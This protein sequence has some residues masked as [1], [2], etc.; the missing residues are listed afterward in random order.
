MRSGALFGV[1]ASAAAAATT[2]LAE[3]AF[4]FR[5]G[6]AGFGF[7]GAFAFAAASEDPGALSLILGNIVCV[8]DPWG[9]APSA[10]VP[11]ADFGGFF[12]DFRLAVPGG[13]GCWPEAGVLGVAFFFDVLG[14]FGFVVAAFGAIS[15]LGANDGGRGACGELLKAWR[16]AVLI[17]SLTIM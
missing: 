17:F 12:F 15:V 14:A 13:A 10:N 6:R 11:L 4:S 7:A 9:P 1:V 16:A 2:T 5:I 8:G 3:E